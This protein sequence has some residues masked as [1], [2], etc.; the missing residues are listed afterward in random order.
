MILLLASGL[1]P[2]ERETV[3]SETAALAR[4]MRARLQALGPD[5]PGMLE[6]LPPPGRGE[7][8]LA[9]GF[10]ALPGVEAVL[11]ARRPAYRVA[12]R[13][14]SPHCIRVGAAAFGSGLASAI[15]GP[16]AVEEEQD[17]PAL[18]VRLREDGAA[19]LRGGAFKPRTSPYTF[20]GLGR[21]GLEKLAEAGRA[22]G[23]PVVTEVLDTRD[24][25][26]VA[27]CVQILQIGSRNMRNYAL[28]AEAGSAGRPV[29]LKRGMSAT[30]AEFLLAAEHLAHAGCEEILLCERGLRHF[31]PA[32]RNLLDL[33]AIPALHRETH[34]PV[35][36]DPSHATGRADLV[37]AM[38]AA[39]AAAGADGFLV[40]VH[41]QPE[42]S[43]SDPEQA[44]TPEAFA[45][46]LEDAEAVLQALGRSLVRPALPVP[47]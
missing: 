22:A 21:R 15:A 42:R 18:A 44:L 30:L 29:L 8:E 39:A 40:E 23:L 43:L 32:L 45:A 16:C 27:A 17:L 12:R 19:C 47:S 13:G 38:M 7:E 14:R 28:L 2:K 11:T 9:A 34:L 36:V 46:A 20:K 5:Q 4:R 41:P 1:T 3:R 6:A 37:P 10:R 31:D 35:L 33:S 26:A 25:E 24:V